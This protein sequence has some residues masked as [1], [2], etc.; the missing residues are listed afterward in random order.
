MFLFCFALNFDRKKIHYYILITRSLTLDQPLNSRTV[1]AI[2]VGR[3]ISQRWGTFSAAFFRPVRPWS[4]AQDKHDISQ[5]IE[6]K[7][8]YLTRIVSSF[9]GVI[10][11]VER[12]NYH[13]YSLVIIRP[14]NSS[15]RS[16]AWENMH[17]RVFQ[18]RSKLHESEG[19]VL[20]LYFSALKFFGTESHYIHKSWL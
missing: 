9:F 19:R 8:I 7:I 5:S 17:E 20:N 18:R 6:S 11:L 14:A 13:L 12:N 4:G 1:G 15:E 10:I 3:K 16:A 2:G